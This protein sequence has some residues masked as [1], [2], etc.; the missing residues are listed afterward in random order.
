LRSPPERIL[1][2]LLLCQDANMACFYHSYR[3]TIGDEFA[4]VRNGSLEYDS[5]L[6]RQILAYRT[7]GYDFGSRPIWGGLLL[8]FHM[9]ADVIGCME[10]WFSNLLHF[11]RRDQLS[12]DYAA[13]RNGFQFTAHDLSNHETRFHRW[14]V[15][16]RTASNDICGTGAAD[17]TPTQ[18]EKLDAL[19]LEI[20]RNPH[21]VPADIQRPNRV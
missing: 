5:V 14:P 16:N 13:R 8:R 18:R 15:A 3:E 11:A 6:L 10:D 19:V 1:A 9:M 7:S 17:L 4:A 20:A 12:F 2:A 21:A